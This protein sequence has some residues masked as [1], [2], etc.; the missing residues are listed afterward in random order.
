MTTKFRIPTWLI[1]LSVAQAG[2]LLVFMNFS[3]ALPLLQEDWGLSNSQA[4]T[5]QSAGQVGYLVSVL[6]MSSLTD[7][8]ESKK[9]IILGSLWAGV[10]NLLFAGFADNVISAIAFR[11]FVG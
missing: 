2:S 6:L 3:G 9:L 8:V 11:A 5:I 4:G 7:Y 10:G 1:A